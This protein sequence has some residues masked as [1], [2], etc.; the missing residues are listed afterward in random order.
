MIHS[1]EGAT[2]YD[3]ERELIR[4]A[5]SKYIIDHIEYGWNTNPHGI[6]E[7]TAFDNQTIESVLEYLEKSSYS[8][9]APNKPYPRATPASGQGSRPQ[10]GLSDNNVTPSST[11][12][13]RPQT[14]LPVGPPLA[15]PSHLA[16]ARQSE[17]PASS[18]ASGSD[19]KSP[20]SA[21][22]LVTKSRRTPEIV[23]HAR[24]YNFARTNEFPALAE[25]ALGRLK[26]R[27]VYEFRSNHEI[28]PDLDTAVRLI[29]RHCQKFDSV[30]DRD[31][32]MLYLTEFVVEKFR[33]LD[34]QALGSL[35]REVGQFAVD[36]AWGLLDEVSVQEQ[37]IRRLEIIASRCSAVT[38]MLEKVK[39]TLMKA[40][41][42][43]RERFRRG[44]L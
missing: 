26:N 8:R 20:P 6:L 36:V 3:V 10:Q 1:G 34:R 4:G 40:K 9:H 25:Y 19:P 30:D 7:L 41:Q 15:N 16:N 35:L 12:S 13:P 5:A 32:A 43:A 11:P 28:F 21:E 24:V 31:P 27:L 33:L 42:R 29:Y 17:T 37:K 39:G 2:R 14:E 22:R 23:V 44:R 38:M 18:A